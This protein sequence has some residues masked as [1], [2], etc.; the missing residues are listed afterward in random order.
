[1]H[2]RYYYYYNRLQQLLSFLLLSQSLSFNDLDNY[3]RQG[4][5]PSPPSRS[6]TI[7]MGITQRAKRIEINKVWQEKMGNKNVFRFTC[8]PFFFYILSDVFRRNPLEN[9]AAATGHGK[10]LCLLLLLLLYASLI[11]M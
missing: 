3:K 9:L 8:F 6:L 2:L 10:F 1:M 11:F 7:G 5:P 4:G